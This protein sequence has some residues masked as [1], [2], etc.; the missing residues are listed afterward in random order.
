[1]WAVLTACALPVIAGCTATTTAGP[2]AEAAHVSPV[3]AAALPGPDQI[4]IVMLENKDQADVVRE[5]PYLRS[6]AATGADLTNMHAETHP[7][8]PNYLALFSGDVQGVINNSCPHTFTAPN[9]ASELA[10]AGLSFVGYAE[11]LPEP[12]YP[13]CQAGG[14][15]RKHIPWTN[16]STVPS[17]AN[18]PLSAM[19]ADYADLPTV[20]FLIPNLCHDMYDCSVAEG[21]TWLQHKIDSYAQWARGHN[22][23]LIVTFDESGSALDT[24]N[25]IMTL[26]VGAMVKPVAYGERVDLD[27]NRS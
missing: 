21:D 8:Q 2:A 18:Q 25:H 14:Y 19:P 6:L 10:E 1:M 16:F 4:M 11:D 15:A 17:S 9:L 20:S 3:A 24:D 23:L 27:P 26:A 12:G 13:G 7:S 22:S 5:A